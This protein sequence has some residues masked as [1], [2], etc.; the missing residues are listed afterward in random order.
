MQFGVTALC[1]LY[2]NITNG[3]E[4]LAAAAMKATGGHKQKLKT[5]LHIFD[6]SYIKKDTLEHKV[7]QS[8]TKKKKQSQ[9]CSLYSHVKE[10]L[11]T[12]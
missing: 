11:Y 9:H 6:S 8:T 2:G 10:Y 4:I 5:I 3:N 7:E 12:K 1:W